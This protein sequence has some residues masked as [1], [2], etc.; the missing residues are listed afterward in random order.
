[1]ELEV[2]LYYQQISY[3]FNEKMAQMFIFKYAL[4]DL[5]VASS[6]CPALFALLSP[7]QRKCL[8]RE[9]EDKF[10]PFSHILVMW[11]ILVCP[12]GP[13]VYLRSY[14]SGL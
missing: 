10:G 4:W 7:W 5:N 9:A 12:M 1:M 13:G 3:P 6:I 11:L 2:E 8:H 14:L